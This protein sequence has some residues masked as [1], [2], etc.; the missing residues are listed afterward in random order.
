MCHTEWEEGRIVL[1]DQVDSVPPGW[2]SGRCRCSVRPGLQWR[3][4]MKCA[5]VRGTLTP[6][7]GVV[8]KRQGSK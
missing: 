1:G 8:L 3:G 6:E 2:K 5:C 7:E 4:G